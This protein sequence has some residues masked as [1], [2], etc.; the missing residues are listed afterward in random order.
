M[1]IGEAGQ[2]HRREKDS[3]GAARRRTVA[4]YGGVG[5]TQRGRGLVSSATV[6][7]GDAN[8]RDGDPWEVDS[9]TETVVVASVVL[10][11]G[12]SMRARRGRE[13]RI[14]KKLRWRWWWH[15]GDV[16]RW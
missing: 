9:A 15:K 6:E 10:E 14:K 5:A 13:I 1:E 4:I 7:A 12:E 8:S 3:G 16:R 2:Q 11:R